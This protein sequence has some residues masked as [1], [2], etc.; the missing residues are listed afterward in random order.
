MESE[1]AVAI[2]ALYAVL[3]LVRLLVLTETVANQLVAAPISGALLSAVKRAATA[4]S[5]V[6]ATNQL[7]G[8]RLLCNC[9]KHPSLQLWMLS[10]RA[11]VRFEPSFLLCTS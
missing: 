6:L 2:W 10:V 5:A 3:D 7:V 9:C 8:L 11:E 4:S 1:S